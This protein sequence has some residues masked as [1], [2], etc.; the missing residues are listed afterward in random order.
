M[1]SR[2]PRK[3]RKQPASTSKDGKHNA[4][5]ATAARGTRTDVS[6]V[7]VT[8]AEAPAAV[9][10]DTPRRLEVLEEI[11]RQGSRWFIEVGLALAEIRDG[12][13]FEQRGYQTFPEY[14]HAE[15]GWQK[16][17]GG[18][19][20]QAASLCQTLSTIVGEAHLPANEAQARAL[21]R[22]EPAQAASVLA[23]AV[24]AAKKADEPVTAR[25]VD[26]LAQKLYPLKKTGLPRTK[27]KAAS[28]ANTSAAG[29]D[30]HELKERLGG[31]EISLAI[32]NGDS[33][34]GKNESIELLNQIAPFIGAGGLIVAQTGWADEANLLEALSE[35]ELTV[36]GRVMLFDDLKQSLKNPV[37]PGT[38]HRA[39]YIA[40]KGKRSKRVKLPDPLDAKGQV[41]SDGSWPESVYEVLVEQLSRRGRVVFIAHDTNSSGATVVARLGGKCVSPHDGVSATTATERPERAG[42]RA[43]RGREAHAE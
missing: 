21:V 14:L 4:V 27:A 3:S 15:L 23:A 16:S 11:V 38:A 39:L 7:I 43:R 20:I 9:P 26:Q 37:E 41:D 29:P 13:L 25:I 5:P 12:R 22:L 1:K 19:L 32:L 35:A 8:R 10:A 36:I 28:A 30:A 40:A 42:R 17:Y 6:P 34:G 33:N 24:K 31:E 18:M 2:K